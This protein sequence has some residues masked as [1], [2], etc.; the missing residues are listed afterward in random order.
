MPPTIRAEELAAWV[1][2]E[3]ENQTRFL[4]GVAGAPGSGKSTLTQHLAE[5]LGA[6]VVPM[7]GFHR[8]NRELDRRGLRNVKGAP[9]TFDA[10][11]FIEAVSNI[12]QGHADLWL[13][14]FDRIS[15]EPRPNRLH[16]PTSAP[17]VIVEGN[18]LLLESAPWS[19]LRALF[20]AVAHLDIERAERVQRLVNRHVQFGK[21]HAAA[22]DFVRASDER[23]ARIVE[24]ASHRAHLIVTMES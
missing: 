24:S 8:S 4:F 18:Y 19:E 12:R 15:D 3:A 6:V 1:R 23:N 2:A 21:S 10:V 17:I 13:P 7:D 11:G 16:V 20:D 22:T 9:Q 5:E 14:D